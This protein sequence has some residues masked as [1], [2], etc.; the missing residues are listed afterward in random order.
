MVFIIMKFNK[1]EDL[2]EPGDKIKLNT[3]TLYNED[4][5]EEVI[6]LLA[7]CKSEIELLEIS[8]TKE[9]GF[10]ECRVNFKLF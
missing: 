4:T 6:E 10:K 7:H 2:F 1:E 3:Q 9:N 5:I 8:Y